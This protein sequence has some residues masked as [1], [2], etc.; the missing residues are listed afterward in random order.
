[1]KSLQ[2]L[3]VRIKKHI[4][5]AVL[6]PIILFSCEQR[7]SRIWGQS[8]QN[9]DDE[10]LKISL[11]HKIRLAQTRLENMHST[12]DEMSA[13]QCQLEE[14]DARI[15]STK[16]EIRD[17]EEKTAGAEAKSADLRARWESSLVAR[18]QSAVGRK[19]ATFHSIHRSYNNAIVKKVSSLGVEIRHQTG[20]ARVTIEQLSEHQILEFGLDREN[21]QKLLADENQSALAFEKWQNEHLKQKRDLQPH[22]NE[23]PSLSPVLSR[24]SWHRSPLARF[25]ARESAPMRTIHR[26]RN[27]GRPRYYYVFPL[28]CYQN[29]QQLYHYWRPNP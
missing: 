13:L 18:R 11:H 20:T 4:A 12:H 15:T 26:V 24:N 1:M 28:R 17:W 19:F 10:I 27:G 22:H 5:I 3:A 7:S 6:M 29:S 21:A 8:P 14:H 9:P 16:N 25:D 23:S 2:L